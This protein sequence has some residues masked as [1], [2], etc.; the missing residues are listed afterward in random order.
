MIRAA[1]ADRLIDA[2]D[3][4]LIQHPV[5]RV[6]TVAGCYTDL[7]RPRLAA[8]S[9]G[10]RDALL[11]QIRRM[12]SG[13]R[14]PGVCAC[15]AC[16]ERNEFD[17][18]AAALP[19]PRPPP[20]GIVSVAFGERT[21]RARLPN[22]YDLAVVAGVSDEEEGARTIVRRCVLDDAAVDDDA[23]AALD[24][25]MEEAEGIAAL[26]IAFSCSACGTANSVPLD[27]GG[28][29]WIELSERVE[30]VIADVETLAARYGWRE[31]DILA[32]SDRRRSL[33]AERARR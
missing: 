11:L 1:P 21:V 10:A 8:L 9:I 12:V 19:A 5:D 16:G 26:D 20:D 6:L 27:I 22:S 30:R 29:L 32:M 17:L 15:E 13:D 7:D 4:G 14:L 28:F 3:A 33:Y 24:R 23:M 18:D 2:W 31:A 25:A